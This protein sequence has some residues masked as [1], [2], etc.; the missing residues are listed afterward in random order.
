MLA[1]TLNHRRIAELLRQDEELREDLQNARTADEAAC[2]RAD[3][4]AVQHSLWLAGYTP[5]AEA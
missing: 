1:L 2:Y 4:H 5:E 3:L